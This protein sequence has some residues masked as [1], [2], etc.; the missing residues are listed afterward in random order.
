LVR[1]TPIERRADHVLAPLPGETFGSMESHM[2]NSKFRLEASVDDQTGRMVA[3]YLRVRE[4]EVATTK[5]V[6]PGVAYAD[7]D[8]Q[9]T[10]LGI[11]LLGPC[12]VAV[13]DTIAEGEPEP[14]RRFLHGGA[15]RELVPA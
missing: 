7:F 14:V 6:E 5:E 10:L 1:V 8:S 9:G 12:Q 4:G 11:E 13:L 3:A 2:S 15:P